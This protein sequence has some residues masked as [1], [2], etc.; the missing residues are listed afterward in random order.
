[1]GN[2]WA[3]DKDVNLTIYSGEKF[4][5]ESDFGTAG[6]T[7]LYELADD[8]VIGTLYFEGF[9]QEANP[10]TYVRVVS[11]SPFNYS[12]NGL[13][14][15]YTLDNFSLSVV[16]VYDNEPSEET[17]RSYDISP[18]VYHELSWPC[19]DLDDIWT[20][21]NYAYQ[22]TD[23]TDSDIE[24]IGTT[25]SRDRNSIEGKIHSEYLYDGWWKNPWETFLDG[26]N[27]LGGGNSGG[28]SNESNTFE[29]N[30]TTNTKDLVNQL[31]AS[32]SDRPSRSLDFLP[33]KLLKIEA[34]T[35][36]KEIKVNRVSEASDNGDL[37]RAK[38]MDRNASSPVGSVLYGG[39]GDDILH[40]LAG[41]D[42]IDGSGGNDLV[43]GGNGRDIIDGGDG[44][45]ELH[46]DFG[47][48]TFESEID[49]ASDLIAIKS[50][51][52]LSNW[53]YGKAGN[54]PNGEKADII[55]G[56]DSNDEIKIIGAATSDLTFGYGS[57]HG[58]NGIGIY[59]KGT[60]EALYTGENLS[61]SQV[62]S[63]TTGD[64]SALAMNNQMWSYRSENVVPS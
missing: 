54:S 32:T 4:T 14:S 40:G 13:L 59:A 42:V 29:L 27:S 8:I 5:G 25:P 45:D 41:W 31:F 62:Q 1:M 30:T 26:S 55:E 51:Q 64:A 53:W 17:V 61:L 34:S 60:L 2:Y 37:L 38:Q 43:H 63:M 35:W 15:S 10:D 3:Y 16:R 12:Q 18:G 23:I 56:L 20:G 52:H 19:L 58:A 46:G 7:G 22:N 49:G 28:G 24:I 57:A 47:W 50:D 21:I 36:N 39:A 48:N 11:T 33:E 6:G 9:N 44:A